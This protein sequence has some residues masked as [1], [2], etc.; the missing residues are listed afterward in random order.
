[1]AETIKVIVGPTDIEELRKQALETL[2]KEPKVD[3][4]VFAAP[5]ADR[6]LPDQTDW[7]VDAKAAFRRQ[8]GADQVFAHY[9]GDDQPFKLAWLDEPL[10]TYPVI[11]LTRT[12]RTGSREEIKGVSDSLANQISTILAPQ[13]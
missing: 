10:E 13:Q 8:E 3:V 5:H 1:M 6:I 2:Q 4:V 9:A 11:N 7:Y 12:G